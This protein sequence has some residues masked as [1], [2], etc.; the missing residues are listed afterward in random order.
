MS[1][2]L[3]QAI[4]TPP[5]SDAVVLRGTYQQETEFIVEVSSTEGERKNWIRAG[6]I[7]RMFDV[8]GIGTTE[9]EVYRLDIEAKKVTFP[10][11]SAPFHL[12]FRPVY[13]LCDYQIR[14]WV[15][16]PAIIIA[17]PLTVDGDVFTFSGI[18]YNF[19]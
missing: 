7:A 4:V 18:V 6:Y 9:G 2:T 8:P 17:T 12:E 15:R 5:P 13:W 10:P 19:N 14:F 11:S 16:D 3:I 1:Y